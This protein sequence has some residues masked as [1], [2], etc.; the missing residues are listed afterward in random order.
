MNSN[1]A[2]AKLAYWTFRFRTA[3]YAKQQVNVVDINKDTKCNLGEWLNGEATQIHGASP[4]LARCLTEHAAF[5]RE[6]YR[7]AAAVNSGNQGDV[8]RLLAPGSPFFQATKTVSD[9]IVEL[10]GSIDG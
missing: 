8:E 5:H 9:T 7:V 2:I 10:F 6:A 4:I 3:V 1:E